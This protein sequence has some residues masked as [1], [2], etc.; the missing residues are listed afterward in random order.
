MAAGCAPPVPESS[1]LFLLRTLNFSSFTCNLS[2]GGV[3]FMFAEAAFEQRSVQL[4][5]YAVETNSPPI[6]QFWSRVKTVPDDLLCD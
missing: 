4:T 3:S 2:A 6:T 5:Q 1:C